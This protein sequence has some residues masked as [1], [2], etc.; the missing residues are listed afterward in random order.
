MDEQRPV[1]QD[2]YCGEAMAVTYM[3]CERCRVSIE[4]QTGGAG[5]AAGDVGFER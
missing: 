2:P 3:S 4:H 1:A 5:Y